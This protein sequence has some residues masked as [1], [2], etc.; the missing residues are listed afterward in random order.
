VGCAP[1][2]LIDGRCCFQPD[3]RSRTNSHAYQT[4]RLLSLCTSPYS[5]SSVS[6]VN[7]A[8][9]T[10]TFLTNNDFN[11]GGFGEWGV[12]FGVL[13]V[14]FNNETRPSLSVPLNLDATIVT[15]NGR[16]YVGFTAA[17]GESVWQ[18]HDLLS[19]WVSHAPTPP[20][21]P[22]HVVVHVCQCQCG[23][24]GLRPL[25]AFLRRP[26]AQLCLCLALCLAL[27]LLLCRLMC[28]CLQALHAVP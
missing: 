10:L 5:L 28:V 4:C 7:D 19:W 12:G 6:Y 3:V 20:S 17:T 8:P 1:V 23:C 27:C 26:L 24:C 21:R 11:R 13:R 18:A 9:H 14:Y 16:A 15:D 22:H 2:C 25:W